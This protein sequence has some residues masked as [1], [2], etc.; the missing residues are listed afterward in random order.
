MV[1]GDRCTTMSK[2]GNCS[3]KLCYRAQCDR[4]LSDGNTVIRNIACDRIAQNAR[5][6]VNNHP[7]NGGSKPLN[8]KLKVLVTN[9]PNDPNGNCG[10]P[11]NVSLAYPHA[12]CTRH[13]SSC[14]TW[15]VVCHKSVKV[16]GLVV[17]CIHR[18]V[19]WA[20]MKQTVV[21]LRRVVQTD[22]ATCT[23]ISSSLEVIW[24]LEKILK[25]ESDQNLPSPR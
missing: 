18:Y 15:D 17:H 25:L 14:T 20:D 12:L 3:I 10:A 19:R 7:V 2:H 16:L 5:D 13:V 6:V 8:D 22:P 23:C 24:I 1:A 9:D 4:R 21:Q 11:R